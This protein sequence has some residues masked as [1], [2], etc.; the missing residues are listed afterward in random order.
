[1]TSVSAK[2]IKVDREKKAVKRML[3][4]ISV[5]SPTGEEV[6]TSIKILLEDINRLWRVGWEEGP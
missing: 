5:K 6:E 3:D 1:M 4:L 2:D